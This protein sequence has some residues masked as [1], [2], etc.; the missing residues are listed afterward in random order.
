MSSRSRRRSSSKNISR[1][2]KSNDFQLFKLFDPVVQ[3]LGIIFFIYCLDSHMHIPYKRVLFS[4]IGWQLLSSAVNFF[5][6]EPKLLK[7]ERGIWFVIALV[8]VG[9]FVAINPT[10]ASRQSMPLN[11]VILVTIGVLLAFWHLVICYREFRKI[12]GAVNRGN[13]R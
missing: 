11:L 6:N 10:H 5:I 7:I 1:S 2:K 12:F 8:Y 3:S 4:L 9:L 13:N